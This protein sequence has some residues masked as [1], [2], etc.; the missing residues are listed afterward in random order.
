M[1]ALSEAHQGTILIPFWSHLRTQI[2]GKSLQSVPEAAPE[3]VLQGSLF[4]VAS[5]RAPVVGGG[6]G[7]G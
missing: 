1:V 7:R 5:V 6:T 3:T 2:T 4:W